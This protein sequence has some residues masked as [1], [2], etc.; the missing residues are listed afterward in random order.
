MWAADRRGGVRVDGEHYRVLGAKRG[1]AP[2]HPVGIW[3]GAYKPR[4]LRLVGRTADGW[5]PSL[6]YLPKGPA[7]LA[8][9]NALVD[10]GASAAGRDPA[11]VRRLLNVCG[12]FTR[13][14]AGFLDGP[15]QQWARELTELV[16]DAR[17]LGFHPRQGRSHQHQLF[18][19]EVAPAVRELVAAERA[20]STA[21][22]RP[23][24][25]AGRR[26]RRPGRPRTRRPGRGQ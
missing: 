3:V 12:R 6:A 8:D 13:A 16:L 10:E 23:G 20:G 19:Q 18:A 17:H 26:R 1:P 11:E 24:H 2:A 4:L 9:R 15:P 22:G 5:L 7:D 14:G 25:G 21:P